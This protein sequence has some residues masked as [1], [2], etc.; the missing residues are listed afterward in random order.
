MGKGSLNTV[1]P[2][3]GC[4]RATLLEVGFGD[5]QCFYFIYKPALPL[6]ILYSLFYT[7]SLS[8]AFGF[9]KVE[10]QQM[11]PNKLPQALFVGQNGKSRKK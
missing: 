11:P 8:L 10:K 1:N 6:S 5:K 3:A 2:A 7:T 4:P 9:I